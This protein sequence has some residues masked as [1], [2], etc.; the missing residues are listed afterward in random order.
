MRF[1]FLFRFVFYFGSFVFCR[2]RTFRE[3]NGIMFGKAFSI[4]FGIRGYYVN[5]YFII[6]FGR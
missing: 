3:L 5:S 6:I 4:A 2:V 1:G